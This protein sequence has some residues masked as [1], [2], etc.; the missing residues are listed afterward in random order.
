MSE[1]SPLLSTTQLLFR[2]RDGEDTAA[3]DLVARYLPILR[4]WARGRLPH[5]VRDLSETEDLLQMTFLRALKRLDDFDPERPGALLAYLR[6]I[7]LNLVRE[8]IRRSSRRGAEVSLHDSLPAPQV[9]AV[10]QLIGS[11]QLEAYEKALGQLPE[12]KRNAVIMRVE[13]G[14]SFQEIATELEKP[15]ANAA[16]MMVSRALDDLAALV[17]T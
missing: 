3:D 11:E 1:K 9:S 17:E 4:R 15:S 16:R 8:E 13:F 10:E 5:R 12:L 6:T 14:M 2:Y 7:L